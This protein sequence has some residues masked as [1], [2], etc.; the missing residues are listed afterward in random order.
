[1]EGEREIY[2]EPALKY[3]FVPQPTKSV[4]SIFPTFLIFIEE[5]IKLWML[6]LTGVSMH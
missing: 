6:L 2:L 4:L 3:Y 1:M 5:N